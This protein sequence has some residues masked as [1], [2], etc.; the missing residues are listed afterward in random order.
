[1]TLSAGLPRPWCLYSVEARATGMKLS[2]CGT[3][4][5]IR[6]ASPYGQIRSWEFSNIRYARSLAGERQDRMEIS[7]KLRVTK[8]GVAFTLNCPTRITELSG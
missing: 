7:N 1:M 6:L 4:P 3:R 8:R 2:P 5:I